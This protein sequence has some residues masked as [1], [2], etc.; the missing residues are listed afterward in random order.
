MGT[1]SCRETLVSGPAI[2]L[3]AVAFSVWAATRFGANYASSCRGEEVQCLSGVVRGMLRVS[4]I[5]HV[6]QIIYSSCIRRVSKS[7]YYFILGGFGQTFCGKK[8]THN[9]RFLHL[10]CQL[11]FFFHCLCYNNSGRIIYCKCYSV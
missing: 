5:S 2:N 1:Q 7:K 4:S 3:I 8:K 10:T 11:T 9:Y 6:N